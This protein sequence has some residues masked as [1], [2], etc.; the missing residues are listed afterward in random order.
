MKWAGRA[1]LGHDAGQMEGLEQSWEEYT[2]A[3]VIY[4]KHSHNGTQYLI[5]KKNG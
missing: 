2:S 4:A 5:K 3:Y 1:G